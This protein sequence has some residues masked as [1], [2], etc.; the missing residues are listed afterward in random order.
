MDIQTILVSYSVIVLIAVSITCAIIRMCHICDPCKEDPNYYF[1]AR[2]RLSFLYLGTA[3]IVVPFLFHPDSPDTLIAVTC[4]P[5][6]FCPITLAY[7]LDRY[8]LKRRTNDSLLVKFHS[9]FFPYIFLLFLLAYAFVGRDNLVR[10][11]L[12]IRIVS[13]ILGIWGTLYLGH[14]VKLMRIRLSSYSIK[15]D[16]KMTVR[17]MLSFSSS[18][19]L[20]FAMVFFKYSW[21]MS[22]F[23]CLFFAFQFIAAT[24]YFLDPHVSPKEQDDKSDDQLGITAWCEAKGYC[25]H[26]ISLEG[27]AAS[28]CVNGRYLSEHI[29]RTYNTDYRTWIAQLRLDE[30]KRILTE[31]PETQIEEVAD[32]VGLSSASSLI[33]L[34]QKYE[35]T[36]P[37]DWQKSS[38]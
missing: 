9:A 26:G 13:I 23:C 6:L 10:Y 31:A 7:L 34:F 35:G 15:P 3:L 18:I 20:S 14:K 25:K 1:P 12:A 36:T 11:E 24:I 4:M 19:T 37:R 33:H 27:L 30:A 2:Y 8:F 38:R 17:L 28:F 16:R 22:L 32:R 5:V 21:F 29:R